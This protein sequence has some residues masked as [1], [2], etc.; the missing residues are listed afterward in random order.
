MSSKCKHIKMTGICK[1]YVY[2]YS[3][4]STNNADQSLMIK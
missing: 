3:S 1:G 2:K 4:F